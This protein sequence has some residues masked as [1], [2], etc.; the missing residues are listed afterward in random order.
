MSSTPATRALHLSLIALYT[1]ATVLFGAV[2][3]THAADQVAGVQ[4]PGG[5]IAAFCHTKTDTSQPSD[6]GDRRTDCCVAC[7]L[8]VAPGLGAR[9]D[10]DLRLPIAGQPVQAGIARTYRTSL[11]RADPTSRGPPRAAL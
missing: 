8:A 11:W 9:F 7:V 10:A 2:M 1:L 4:L 5:E 3:P 6:D